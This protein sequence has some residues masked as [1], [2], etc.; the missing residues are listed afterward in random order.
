MQP[1][2]TLEVAKL[3]FNN[4]NIFYVICKKKITQKRPKENIWGKIG[5]DT[6]TN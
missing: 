5:E 3:I 2:D 1:T 6:A 4:F